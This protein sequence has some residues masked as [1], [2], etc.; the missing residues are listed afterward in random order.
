MRDLAGARS[1]WVINNRLDEHLTIDDIRAN[2]QA[3]DAQ[4]DALLNTVVRCSSTTKG[5]R[6]YWKRRSRELAAYIQKLGKPAVFFT[7]SAADTQWDSLQRHLPDYWKWRHAD[8]E[9]R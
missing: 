9:E 7:F 4:S 8:D 5:T 6:P 2:L 1:R 3:D